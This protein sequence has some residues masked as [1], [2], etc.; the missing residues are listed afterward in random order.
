MYSLHSG[1]EGLE[2]LSNQNRIVVI[3]NAAL[4]MHVEEVHNSP[5]TEKVPFEIHSVVEEEEHSSS[6]N[7]EEIFGTFTFNL[8]RKEVIQNRVR[9]VKQDDG[10]LEEMQEDEVLF[11][12]T[13]EDPVMV[14][15]T[16][17]ALTQ[18]T[19]HNIL[20]LNEKHFE[21]KSKNLKLKDELISLREKMKKRSKFNDNLAPL[22]ENILEQQEQLHDVKVECFTEI[23]NMADNVKAFEKNLE[24][25]SQINQKMESCIPKL[26]NWTDG[27][28]WIKI[29]QVAL[30][31]SKLMI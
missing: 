4:P 31:Q 29:F 15:T 18:D 8:H 11:E 23:Q 22:K 25:V 7:I 26:R 27:G 16:L 10:T 30:Q 28:I 24:I 2:F 3:H 21:A 9:L 17:A 5:I 19:T 14:D 13:N 12:K 6:Y 1:E 20:V